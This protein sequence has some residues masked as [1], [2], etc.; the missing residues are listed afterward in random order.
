MFLCGFSLTC[1]AHKGERRVERYANHLSRAYKLARES[2]CDSD[3]NENWIGIAWSGLDY[4]IQ[5]CINEGELED[6][7]EKNAQ[8]RSQNI[9]NTF[10]GML[11]VGQELFFAS[12]IAEEDRDIYESMGKFDEME[13]PTQPY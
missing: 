12:D 9:A 2:D 3:L 5:E 1:D 10:G 4:Y 13:R 7:E 8:L 6:N 11:S